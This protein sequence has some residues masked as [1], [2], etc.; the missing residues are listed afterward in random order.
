MRSLDTLFLT[1]VRSVYESASRG[2]RTAIIEKRKNSAIACSYQPERRRDLRI[3]SAR[4][5]ARE[6]SSLGGYD[7]NLILH[8]CVYECFHSA[9]GAAIVPY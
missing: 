4:T 6:E 9:S 1:R 2:G 5:R 7:D 3:A 8:F